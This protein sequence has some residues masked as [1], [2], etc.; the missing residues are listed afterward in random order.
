[1]VTTTYWQDR[2]Y[3]EAVT[4]YRTLWNTFVRQTKQHKI[5]AE[6]KFAQTLYERYYQCLEETK[7]SFET[8][9]QVAKEYR[10]TAI[11]TFGAQSSIAEAT[12][13]LAQVS[14]R[15]E[16]HLSQAISLYEEASKSTKTTT[17]T[18]RSNE[19]KQALSSLY[20]RQMK[21]Q[22]SSSYKAEHV[23]RA[24]SMTQEQLTESTS[25]HGY[26][27]ESSLSHVKEL[28]TLY[29]RQQKSDLAVR[30]LTTA[31]SEI[32]LKETSSQKQVES[33]ASI[34]ASFLRSGLS[35]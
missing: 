22:S 30:T 6:E 15:S 31:A 11:A 10:E 8:L 26:S 28:A 14:Q 32:I 19:M 25:K 3:A 7:A 13:A 24:L 23:E 18:T 17:T 34:A 20:V 2:R 1:M 4:I 21:S 27:H 29:Q 9:Y 16:E 12:L 35:T 5:F 33:A